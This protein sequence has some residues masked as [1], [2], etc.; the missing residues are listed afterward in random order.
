MASYLQVGVFLRLRH[1][2]YLRDAPRTLQ[3]F[4]IIDLSCLSRSRSTA[5]FT[6]HRHFL[7]FSNERSASRSHYL[8]KSH[9][10]ALLSHSPALLLRTTPTRC[11]LAHQM[12]SIMRCI[13]TLYSNLK[14]CSSAAEG[15]S[16]ALLIEVL[17]SVPLQTNQA[18]HRSEGGE[19][20]AAFS[21]KDK[22]PTCPWVA[23][24]TSL[25]RP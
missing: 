5:K 21:G 8:T 15:G 11:K 23:H 24:C 4:R 3:R 19:L 10:R 9:S 18:Y 25:Y 7:T 17:G 22:T 12:T 16:H 13:K 14:E 20:I 2:Q 1:Y 6:L